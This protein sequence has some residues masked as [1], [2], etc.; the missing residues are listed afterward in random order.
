M[1]DMHIWIFSITE[2]VSNMEGSCRRQNANCGCLSGRDTVK[3][4]LNDWD[5]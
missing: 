1:K 3:E 4:E 5:R 2:G